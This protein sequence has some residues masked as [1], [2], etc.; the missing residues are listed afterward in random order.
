MS[1]RL[2]GALVDRIAQRRAGL[3]IDARAF[4]IVPGV[5]V[6]VAAA[7]TRVW[8]GRV[9]GL[10]LKIA[11]PPGTNL[12]GFLLGDDATATGIR[13]QGGACIVICEGQRVQDMQ[14]IKGL[15]S[16][17][18]SDLLSDEQGFSLL[19]QQH[20]QVAPAS[21]SAVRQALA[22][23]QPSQRPPARRVAGFIDAVAQGTPLGEALPQL[24]AFRDDDSVS[25]ERIFENLALAAVL[26]DADLL[27]PNSLAAIR[28]RAAHHLGE[29]AEHILGLLRTGSDQ[30]LKDISFADAR[31]ILTEPP[32]KELA[33]QVRGDL[34]R[35]AETQDDDWVERA[36]GHAPAAPQLNDEGDRRQAAQE[37]LDF[38]DEVEQERIDQ[39]QIPSLF[40]NKTRAKLKALLRDR[41]ISAKP[42]EESLILALS[43][44]A[45]PAHIELRKPSLPDEIAKDGDVRDVL[46]IAA[47]RFRAAPIL[48][49]LEERGVNVFGE[50]HADLSGRLAN[51]LQQGGGTGAASPVVL[52]V[53]GETRGDHVEIT[54]TPTAEDVALVAVNER[55][56]SDAGGTYLTAGGA[57]S[58][59][60]LAWNNL[61]PDLGTHG[62]V[63][64]VAVAARRVSVGGLD[65][66]PLLR[67][68]QSW[69]DLVEK[70]EEDDAANADLTKLN[71]AGCVRFGEQILAT[72][73]HPLKAEWLASRAQA[74]RELV[75]TTLE[76]DQRKVTPAV[77]AKMAQHLAGMT[78]SN[79]P[80]FMRRH[81][82]AGHLLPTSDGQ[83]FSVFG[84]EQRSTG[85]Q[86]APVAAVVKA[87][88]KLADLHPESRPQLRVA[89]LR[90]DAS[91][92]VAKA[93]VEELK[94]TGSRFDAAELTCI[95]GRPREQTLEAVEELVKDEEGRNISIRYVDIPDAL[96]SHGTEDS[97]TV[98]LGVIAGLGAANGRRIS[99]QVAEIDAPPQD[100]DPLFTPKIWLRSDRSPAR[101]LAPAAATDPCWWWLKLQTA[102]GSHWPIP[103]DDDAIK[104]EV[105]EISVDVHSMRDELVTMH[106]I[107]N[108]VLTVDRY[109]TRDTLDAAL[110]QD[111][112]ILHQERR[113]SASVTEG[114]VI[115]QRT[116]G[117][118]DRAIARAL[119][120]LHS[121]ADREVAAALGRD[122]RRAASRGHG[123]LAL[124]AATTGSGINELIGH[125]AGFVAIT[126][127]ASAATLP[128]NS[129][130]LL[131][132]LDEYQDW[133]G[134]GQRADLLAL[135]L[136]RDADREVWA[137]TVE[138]KAA[139]S[140]AGQQKALREAKEQLR[141]TMID[142]KF[143][144]NPDGSVFSR[145]WLN[146]IVEAAVGVVR[147]NNIRLSDAEIR[148][149]NKFRSEGTASGDFPGIALA[150][151][152]E[153][154]PPRHVRVTIDG[155]KP[156]I[157][158]LGI[159]LNDE[160]L[161]KAAVADPSRLHT[162]DDTA[163]HLAPGSKNRRRRDNGAGPRLGAAEKVEASVADTTR[164]QDEGGGS[165][166]NATAVVRAAPEPAE[167][168]EARHPVLGTLVDGSQLTWRVVGEG[169]LANGHVE[170][171]GT[172]GS[173]K[174]QFVKS[175]LAQMQGMGS[176]FGVL[177]FKD[178]Y[179]LDNHNNY[180]PDEVGAR[181]FELWSDPVPYN[182]LAGNAPT[183]A[184]L[185]SF[186][187]EIRDTVATAVR[188]FG[189]KMGH[190][191]QASL[192]AA[193][194]ESFKLANAAGRKEPTF[195]DLG[196]LLDDDLAGIIGDLFIVDLFG[197]G[198]P[199]G[200]VIN[201][202]AVFSFSHVPGTGMSA[203]L[204]AGFILSSIYLKMHVLP[205]VANVVR[206]T[207]VIDEAH[208][209]SDFKAVKSMVREQRSKGLAVILATQGPGDL[210][211]EVETNAQTKI[212][213]RLPSDQA[214]KAARMLDPDDR[215]LAENIRGLNDAEAYVSLGGRPP[216][217]VRL[218]QFWKDRAG[219]GA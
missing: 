3:T 135:A 5:S 177:D 154:V 195:S 16:I 28:D 150:F 25:S 140:A 37:L 180:F 30:L 13:N 148:A 186:C 153:D 123:V 51:A 214:K 29:R 47:L 10:T 208:R 53:K 212:V 144:I 91:D 197:D 211:E 143:A 61:H 188:G 79:Y 202:N 149:L 56:A 85:I 120:R 133:F 136:P 32:P 163:P 182:P 98:H 145:L 164:P 141:Q 219:T 194:L 122:L 119:M 168:H 35:F 134:R 173:G 152:P 131:I 217:L 138:V 18:P 9:A 49:L 110:N 174:T 38:D 44:L 36:D 97:P 81:D 151:G 114:L 101:L 196:A 73:L 31:K 128:P 22:E 207:L 103:T 11:A 48:A 80:A 71:L 4:F 8:S 165:P 45:D 130:V 17:E 170:V 27:R 108:W 192:M 124:R 63:S 190:R 50:F 72:H 158:M 115:S 52:A 58:L 107:A 40:D 203:T 210:P 147:E 118:A 46:A 59:A 209:V 76:G 112:A 189:Q 75:E 142:S 34:R 155:D 205:A 104:I 169:A 93:L 70:A 161:R 102:L 106:A 129:R 33:E 95:G 184:E 116:G 166:E 77:I 193:L 67:W 86:P 176:K 162:G 132:S 137:A 54:W 215:D 57:P 62:K 74:W 12:P 199:L 14:G 204:A 78:A 157:Q 160:L 7:M 187:I 171:Y 83:I 121:V 191:Q 82:R 55:F 216:E 111:V 6:D 84:G 68:V 64:P 42:I 125:V 19:L 167:V 201:E 183:H 26:E 41:K 87:L 2:A 198:P 109:A 139:E 178:D 1:D 89:A 99:E 113:V 23:L 159:K 206:Y 43:D 126:E 200:E 105:P 175:L 90:D 179:G 66:A 213:L 20:P 185:T 146:R 172:S 100:D 94:R 181:L 96:R 69:Q 39:P 156:T 117:A 88:H 60:G 218:R 15:E 24:G 65:A 92:L 127:R 21:V